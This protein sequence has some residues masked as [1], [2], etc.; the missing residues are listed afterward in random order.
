MSWPA[1]PPCIA[2]MTQD[3]EPAVGP[4]IYRFAEQV[5]I[6]S[7]ST[8]VHDWAPEP[9]TAAK[10][11][12]RAILCFT[13]A[14]CVPL[15]WRWAGSCR[16]WG[17]LVRM[18]KDTLAVH[19]SINNKPDHLSIPS[20]RYRPCIVLQLIHCGTH[21]SSKRTSNIGAAKSES[22]QQQSLRNPQGAL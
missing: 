9:T 16:C 22:L 13:L 2:R 6:D 5:T 10:R 3:E 21:G 7:T 17:L 20:T 14:S 19:L 8:P 1:Q 4:V 11:R 12:S 18:I 15:C